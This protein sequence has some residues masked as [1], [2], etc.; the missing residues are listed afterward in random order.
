VCFSS[1]EW[2]CSSFVFFPA[3][4]FLVLERERVNEKEKGQTMDKFLKHPVT[5]F[6]IEGQCEDSRKS[7]SRKPTGARF[8]SDVNLNPVSDPRNWNF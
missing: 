6:T 7:I 1:A 2:A 3:N 5:T 4:R 8:V